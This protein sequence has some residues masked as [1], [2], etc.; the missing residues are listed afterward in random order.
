M[1]EPIKLLDYLYIAVPC[2]KCSNKISIPFSWALGGREIDCPA[3][4]HPYGIDVG[5][6][7]LPKLEWGFEEFQKMLRQ[8]GCWVEVHSYP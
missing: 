8:Q 1:E 2:P 5:G 6:S 3:C 4:G 7:L